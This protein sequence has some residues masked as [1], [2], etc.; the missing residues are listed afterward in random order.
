MTYQDFEDLPVCKNAVELAKEINV[1]T[2]MGSF[3]RDFGLKDQ[4]RRAAVSIASNIAEGF[5]RSN[6][7]EFIRFL[8]YAK[9]SSSEVRTQLLIAR[10]L[11]HLNDEQ[12][13]NLRSQSRVLAV[14]IG[15]LIAY[16]KDHLERN[17]QCAMRNNHPL[18]SLLTFLLNRATFLRHS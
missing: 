16:L 9:G 14:S 3:A 7:K 6:N 12:Y 18:A 1:L 2:G 13:A 15:K 4:I 5:E 11:N 17:A 8:Y 10:D